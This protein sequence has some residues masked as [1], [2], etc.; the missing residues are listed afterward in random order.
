M[1]YS[2]T[3]RLQV[4]QSPFFFKI[5]KNSKKIAEYLPPQRHGGIRPDLGVSV[6]I[7]V[8][9]RYSTS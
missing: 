3:Y 4:A 9:Q 2:A 1:G 6:M 8:M 5:V 7:C